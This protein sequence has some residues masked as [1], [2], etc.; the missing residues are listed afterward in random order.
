[1]NRDEGIASPARNQGQSIVNKSTRR[2]M[3]GLGGDSGSLPE[4][5]RTSRCLVTPLSNARIESQRSGGHK[6]LEFAKEEEVRAHLSLDRP[7]PRAG[8]GRVGGWGGLR[9]GISWSCRGT[10]GSCRS[11]SST[12]KTEHQ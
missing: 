12:C 3:D 1:M 11:S 6:E 9:E 7:N 10:A 8:G 2:R 5:W 4:A